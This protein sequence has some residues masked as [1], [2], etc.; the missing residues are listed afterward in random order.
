MSM[1]TDDVDP[2]PALPEPPLAVR[3]APKRIYLIISDDKCHYDEE[4]PGDDVTWC[5]DDVEDCN[6]EYVRADLAHPPAKPTASKPLEYDWLPEAR[7]LAAQCWCDPTTSGIAMDAALAEVVA[8]NIAAWM[9]TGAFH[10]RNE[11]Y[12][13]ERAELAEA[14]MQKPAAAAVELPALS[15]QAFDNFIAAHAHYFS[16]PLPTSKSAPF[17]FQMWCAAVQADRERRN[18]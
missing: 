9:Q 1:T 15:E 8:R 12:W 10:A 17:Y 6:V 16:R 2:L 3:T 5:A 7:Q 11:E 18:G 14:R 4:F 13:R